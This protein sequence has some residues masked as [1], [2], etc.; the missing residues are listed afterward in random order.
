MQIFSWLKEMFN[1]DLVLTSKYWLLLCLFK[2]QHSVRAPYYYYEDFELA[3]I[4]NTY[5]YLQE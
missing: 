1:I 3:L 4:T 5:N 2:T